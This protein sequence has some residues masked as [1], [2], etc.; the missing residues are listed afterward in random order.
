MKKKFLGIKIGTIFIGLLCLAVAFAFWFFV[1]YAS[2]CAEPV[3]DSTYESS[4][5]EH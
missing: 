2:I 5:Y 4:I 1:K 3:T